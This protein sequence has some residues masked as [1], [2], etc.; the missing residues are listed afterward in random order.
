[1]YVLVFYV[2]EEY[3]VPV[4]EA[5]F[6]A[7]A[8]ALSGYERCAWQVKGAGQ[9][10]PGEGSSPFLGRPGRTVSATEYRVE[11]VCA[12]ERARAAVEALFSSHPYEVPA[13]HL[14]PVRTA[15]DLPRS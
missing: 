4:K 10:A 8:G 13:Y 11:M 12:E 9:F 6:A 2:P 1:M 15:E 7:G 3:L 14:I 5:L